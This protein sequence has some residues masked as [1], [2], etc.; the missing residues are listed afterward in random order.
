MNNAT[1]FKL[2]LGTE[3]VARIKVN[4]RHGVTA[5]SRDNLWQVLAS[6]ISRL[7]GAPQGTNAAYVARQMLDEVIADLPAKYRKDILD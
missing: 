2:N 5:M 4:R 1:R 3:L 6:T 7:P